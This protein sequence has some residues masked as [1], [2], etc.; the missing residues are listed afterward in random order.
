MDL[1]Y[2]TGYF[3]I[4]FLMF[5]ENV[6]PPIPS[7]VI[8]P[9]AGYMATQGKLS[10]VGIVIAGTFG[11]VLGALP[12]YYLGRIISEDRLNR[13]ADKHGRW[14]TIS[15]SDIGRAKGW[16]DRRGGLAVFIC[17]LI[18]GIRSLISIPA[19]INKMNLALFLAYT[20]AGA[21]IWTA[22]LA[23]LG[24]FLGSSFRKVGDYL[25][26]VAS[27]VWGIVAVIYVVRVIRYK[28]KTASA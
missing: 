16:F 17:R 20:A 12:F 8:M 9:L 14:L 23:Y 25:D 27:V 18:P 22:L 24:Y 6:F 2:A 4:V 21:M 7:E 13:L 15:R 1:I 19:G 28:R 5:I 10:F 3:G 26:P 11:S